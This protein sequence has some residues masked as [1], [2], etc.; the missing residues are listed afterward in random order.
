MATTRRD[1]A[2]RN[3]ARAGVRSG[4][5]SGEKNKAARKQASSTNKTRTVTRRK[6]PRK[7]DPRKKTRAAAPLFHGPS[8]SAGALLGAA[9]VILGAW[10]PELWNQPD[11]APSAS[12][13]QTPPQPMKFEFHDILSS[14]EVRADT[15]VYQPLP[16]EPA[17]AIAGKKILIQA[18]SFREESDAEALRAQLLL[19]NL[20]VVMA[21]VQIDTG[22]WYRVTVG[23]F[24]NNTEANRAMTAL[25][26]QDLQAI[27]I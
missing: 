14:S 22:I 9:V 24:E 6:A 23:P 25:R 7:P 5:K 16:R 27:F 12:T 1:Y 18:A 15:S 13:T 11:A 17:S 10:L 4:T 26:R 20:P 8:F 21:R 19:Q 2:S 3:N